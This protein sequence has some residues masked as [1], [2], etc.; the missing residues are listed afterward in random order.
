MFTIIRPNVEVYENSWVD[1][2]V[3]VIAAIVGAYPNLKY[4]MLINL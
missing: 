1:I 4:D 2:Y 3:V